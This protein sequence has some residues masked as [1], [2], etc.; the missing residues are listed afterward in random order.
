MCNKVATPEQ[1][2]LEYYCNEKNIKLFPTNTYYHTSAFERP[3]LPVQ[4]SKYADVIGS[5]WW[6]LV[7][8]HINGEKSAED[9][10][11][12]FHTQNAR[13]EEIFNKPTFRPYIGTQRALLY[14]RGFYEPHR[15]TP[16]V[17]VPYFVEMKDRSMFTLGCVYSIFYMDDGKPRATISIITTE[18]NDLLARVHNEKLRMPLVIAQEDRAK[19]LGELDREGIEAMIKPL[20]D[21]ML[22]AYEISKDVDRP[23]ADKDYPEILTPVTGEVWD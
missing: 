6:P 19:W 4:L 12:Q 17:S 22:Q 9:F 2:E 16:K 5:A 21:G 11:R 8:E 13:G 3:M 23:R 15:P 20:P 10:I 7:P 14:V 18:P 1:A